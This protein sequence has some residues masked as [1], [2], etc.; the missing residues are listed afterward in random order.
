MNGRG[1][2]RGR[3]TVWASAARAAFQV[4]S[5]PD[6]IASIAGEH[7]PLDHRLSSGRELAWIMFQRSSIL[8]G[9][10]GAG[11]FDALTRC[12]FS[13]QDCGA[14]FQ[15]AL[16]AISKAQPPAERMRDLLTSTLRTVAWFVIGLQSGIL[17]GDGGN[18]ASAQHSARFNG[19]FLRP[20]QQF[21]CT[22][23]HLL[24]G[25]GNTTGGD[26]SP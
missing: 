2:P 7:F 13:L 17:S 9:D 20:G 23:M 21:S 4:F 10:R 12:G 24:P 3:A 8:T 26:R 11:F 16:M 22:A 6:V 1:I 5:P 14:L 18:P 25:P 19:F 15:S